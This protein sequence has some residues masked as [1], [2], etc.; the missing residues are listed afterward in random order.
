MAVTVGVKAT[1]FTLPDENGIPFHLYE[2][3]KRGPLVIY[4]FPRDFTSGCTA[5]ACEFRDNYGLFTKKGVRVAGIS[6][7]DAERHTSFK[8]KHSLPFRLLSDSGHRIAD[9]F[10]V[11]RSLG[12]IPGRATFL[13]GKDGT[14]LHV[15]SS[16]LE[17]KRHIAESL[18]AIER[19]GIGNS[20]V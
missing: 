8:Q 17:P 16:Q 19:A 2:E 18:N 14:V 3:L 13:I 6:T 9:M 15:F 7:D 5:E 10:G 11:R 12:I 20:A 4:F 1:D